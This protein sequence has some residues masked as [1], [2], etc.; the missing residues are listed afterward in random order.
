MN[1][2]YLTQRPPA[3]GTFPGKPFN[4]KSFDTREYVGEIGRTVRSDYD[5]SGKPGTTQIILYTERKEETK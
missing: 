1:R 2:Y 4:L 5:A 3:P